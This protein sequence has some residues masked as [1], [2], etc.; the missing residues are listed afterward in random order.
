MSAFSLNLVVA[1]SLLD[2]EFFSMNMD[3][4]S[5]YAPIIRNNR[6]IKFMENIADTLSLITTSILNINKYDD[7]VIIYDEPSRK[8]AQ[9]CRNIEFP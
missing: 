4:H 8:F 9:I 6:N 7:I 3:S 1:A 5:A 2:R